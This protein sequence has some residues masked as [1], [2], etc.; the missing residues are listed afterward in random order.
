MT[1]SETEQEIKILTEWLD[2]TR[3]ILQRV[4]TREDL[5]ADMI[6]LRKD[7]NR[8]AANVAN[9]STQLAAFGLQSRK[10]R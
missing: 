4:A 3:Q 9:M 1:A 6:G 10:R 8:L 5:K 2:E 7:L